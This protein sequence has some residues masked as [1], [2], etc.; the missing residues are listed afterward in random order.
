MKNEK[1]CSIL[2]IL[3]VLFLGGC[4]VRPSLPAAPAQGYLEGLNPGDILETRTGRVISIEVLLEQL[5]QA[6][7]VYLG[8]THTRLEDHQIQEQILKGL[9]G[10]HPSLIVALEMF[11]RESQPLLDRFLRGEETEEEFL[12]GVNWEEIWGYPFRLYRPLVLFA[13]EKGLPLVGLNAPREVVTKIARGGLAGL[14]PEERKRVAENFDLANQGHR[15]YVLEE[16]ERHVKGSIRDFEA[17]YEAQLAWE[18]TMAETLVQTLKAAPETVRVVVL[19][20]NGHIWQG[21]GVPNNARRRLNHQYRTVIPLP[22]DYALRPL[23]PGPADYIWVTPVSPEAHRPRLG[24][25][26]QTLP[27]GGGIAIGELTAGGRA[28][29]AGFQKGDVIKNVNGAPVRNLEDMHRSLSDPTPFKRFG[30]RRN[31]TEMEIPVEWEMKN[32]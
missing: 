8:E 1:R 10:R 31:G 4:C 22:A 26:I 20:G 19:I 12:R 13:R 23:E 11:P 17:F 5:D 28:D 14:S 25:T 21:R 2:S 6:R 32:P 16:Y 15:E 30:I 29:K 7:V 18:E 27:D 9:Y 3:F 24:I